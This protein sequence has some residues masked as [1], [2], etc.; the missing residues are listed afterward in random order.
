MI[1][2]SKARCALRHRRVLEIYHYSWMVFITFLKDEKSNVGQQ[3]A[4][5]PGLANRCT[6]HGAKNRR[7][8]K[9]RFWSHGR[10]LPTMWYLAQLLGPQGDHHPRHHHAP[11]LPPTPPHPTPRLQPPHNL[12]PQ[13]ANP[14]PPPYL[15]SPTPVSIPSRTS[16]SMHSWTPCRRQPGR[17]L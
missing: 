10:R 11:H 3:A 4:G 15:T 17:I 8:N 7:S 1:D 13:H 2:N 14:P 6:H 9:Q 12:L 5:G 16:S